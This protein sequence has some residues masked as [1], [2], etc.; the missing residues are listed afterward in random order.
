RIGARA[1]ARSW[2][3]R[4]PA[5]PTTRSTAARLPRASGRA[6]CRDRADAPGRLPPPDSA[7]ASGPQA[8]EP[9]AFWWERDLV[10]EGFCCAA[11]PYSRTV[12]QRPRRPHPTARTRAIGLVTLFG[13]RDTGPF[14]SEA[15]VF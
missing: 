15:R 14:A 3:C 1:K 5:A 4:S 12:A 10:L 11:R 2:S 8:A 7:D 6:S 13:P 9:P